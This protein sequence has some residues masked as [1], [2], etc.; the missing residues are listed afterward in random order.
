M[1]K[2]EFTK[3]NHKSSCD[4]FAGIPLRPLRPDRFF[5]Q[6]NSYIVTKTH[7]LNVSLKRQVLKS[8]GPEKSFCCLDSPD[9]NRGGVDH[10]VRR[11]EL[12]KSAAESPFM[13]DCLSR[14]S[15]LIISASLGP[16]RMWGS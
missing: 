13:T 5:A 3:P 15:N 2:V 6:H 9:D 14:F 10:H 11:P 16:E 7:L 8:T 12:I 1:H 4:K